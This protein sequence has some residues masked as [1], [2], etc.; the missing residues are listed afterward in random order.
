MLGFLHLKK[1]EPSKVILTG[2]QFFSELSIK[3]VK[4]PFT[5]LIYQLSALKNPSY[6]TIFHVSQKCHAVVPQCSQLSW[7]IISLMRHFALSLVHLQ[8]QF[9]HLNFRKML[10]QKVMWYHRRGSCG[11]E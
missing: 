5:T 3:F 1:Y 10:R 11:L 8:A 7:G 6:A 4:M 9:F 2:R